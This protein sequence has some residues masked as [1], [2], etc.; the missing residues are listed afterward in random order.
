MRTYEDEE[1]EE[2]ND[3]L[4]SSFVHASHWKSDLNFYKHELNFLT[5]LIN[6]YFIYL[7]G[8]ND[9]PS[10]PKLVARLEETKK[11]HNELSKDITDYMSKIKLLMTNELSLENFYQRKEHIM[12]ETSFNIF[13]KALRSLKRHI[14][15]ITEEVMQ[16]KK[17]KRLVQ[18]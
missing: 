4:T 2:N 7:I 11:V 5:T 18:A 3:R 10:L 8:E 1:M 12:L 13:T 16:H 17:M 6:K 9:L 14:F 15:A